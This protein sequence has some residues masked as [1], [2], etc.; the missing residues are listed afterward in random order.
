V[1]AFAG[2]GRASKLI[3]THC[4]IMALEHEANSHILPKRLIAGRCWST[5]ECLRCRILP[6]S[7]DGPS[8][9]NHFEYPRKL[10][11]KLNRVRN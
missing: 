6:V 8:S 1:I 7:V 3:V 11:R 9:S 10:E 2:I 5:L 4:L